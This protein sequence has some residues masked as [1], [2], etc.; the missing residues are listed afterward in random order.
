MALSMFFMDKA[1]SSSLKPQAIVDLAVQNK[2]DQDPS[3]R[4]LLHYHGSKSIISDPKFF[5]SPEGASNLKAKLI[6]TIESFFASPD[7]GDSHSICRFPAR[8]D[9]LLQK[10]NLNRADFP[11]PVSP[12]LK[13]FLNKV[14]A[15]TVS[16]AFASEN[17]MVPVSMMGHLFLKIEGQ[18]DSREVSH[19]LSYFAAFTTED[20]IFFYLKSIFTGSNGIY[21]LSPY[22][23]QLEIYNDQEKRNIWEYRLNL[24]SKQIR[25][26]VLH[27]WEMKGI[28]VRYNFVTHNCG[29]GVVYLLA[30][31]IPELSDFTH[32][33]WITPLDSLKE[34]YRMN[35]IADVSIYPTHAY[36]IRMISQH[37]SNKELDL[38]QAGIDTKNTKLLH[39]VDSDQK[40]ADILCA[41]E[42]LLNARLAE[43]KISSTDY[44]QLKEEILD[45]KVQLPHSDLPF[46]TKNPMSGHLSSRIYTGYVHKKN[47]DVFHLGYYP[48]YNDIDGNN[49][50]YFNEFQLYFL[51]CDLN[52]NI[53][54]EHFQIENIDLINMKSILPHDTLTGGLS[55]GFKL[56]FQSPYNSRNTDLYFNVEGDLG[57][58][59]SF[60]SEK[61]TAY[62][63]LD[64][65]YSRYTPNIPYVGHELG[66][67]WRPT[68][69]MKT[70]ALLK[71]YI[72][73][74]IPPHGYSSE[75]SLVLSFFISKNQAIFS[76]YKQVRYPAQHM[77]RIAEIGY[78]YYF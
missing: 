28:N 45:L 7:L 41:T 38:I 43:N 1:F 17:L 15:H 71:T 50:E 42:Y 55:G 64:I 61:M 18:S 73:A 39:A 72:Y 10:L 36:K 52:Y 26:L 16:I 75:L 57:L 9:W 48:V 19:A 56:N 8:F 44:S 46:K 37:F 6:A 54:N 67:F 14:G 49:R 65:G 53:S 66:C 59:Y 12:L 21:S 13:E 78:G 2:L 25:K 62:V 23:K 29:S 58:A 31:V 11:S 20:S 32:K 63:L 30:A 34:L 47:N 40:K 51:N 70:H 60:F 77:D 74:D 22:R 4:I 76:E 68:D 35:Y 3:W 33:P 27:I 69:W 5:N 24:T